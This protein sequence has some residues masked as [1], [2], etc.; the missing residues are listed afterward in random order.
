MNDI[1]VQLLKIP[2]KDV[3]FI[4]LHAHPDD[5]SFLTAGLMHHLVSEKREVQVIFLAAGLNPN[6]HQTQIRRKEA[7]AACKIIGISR[8]TF[9][10]YF[11]PKY[12]KIVGNK[13]LRSQ[14]T[15]TLV[16]D[17]YSHIKKM[18]KGRKV[19]LFSYDVNGGY[20]NQDHKKLHA[21]GNHLQTLDKKI[22]VFESTINRTKFTQWLQSNKK[23]PLNKLPQLSYWQKKFGHAEKEIQYVY[24]LSKVELELKMRAMHAHTSQILQGHFPLSLSK[25]NFKYLFGTEYYKVGTKTAQ[26]GAWHS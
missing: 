6:I 4:F 26:K 3:V 12:F 9:L 16:T 14:K 2:A 22:M 5:E 19:I 20:G 25:N 21:I 8:P 13:T 15:E 23:L 18:R 7:R 11:E 24:T 1:L 10:N 17:I